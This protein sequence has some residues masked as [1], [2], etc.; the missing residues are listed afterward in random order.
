MNTSGHYTVR[1]YGMNGEGEIARILC[2]YCEFS[3][4][5]ADHRQP[6]DKSGYPRYNKARG[7]MV[8]HLHERHHDHLAEKTK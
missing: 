8:K 5:P 7:Q 6:S 3:C 2:A 4:A 1:R